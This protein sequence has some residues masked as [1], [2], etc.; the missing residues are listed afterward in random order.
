[1]ATRSEP[2]VSI[3]GAEG[4]GIRASSADL[5]SEHS[6][7][8]RLA[9]AFISQCRRGITEACAVPSAKAVEGVP[10]SAEDSGHYNGSRPFLLAKVCLIPPFSP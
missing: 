10:K 5:G 3:D 6:P 9:R 7:S 1:M 2:F 8:F 4:V